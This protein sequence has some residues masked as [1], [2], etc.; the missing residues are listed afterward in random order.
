MAGAALMPA[1]TRA[2]VL[3]VTGHSVEDWAAS[4]DLKAK[5]ESG[6]SCET[7]MAKLKQPPTTF[8]GTLNSMW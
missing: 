1:Q 4:R 2:Y 8:L 7:L 3:S 6:V 5:T